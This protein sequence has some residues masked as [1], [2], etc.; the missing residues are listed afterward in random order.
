MLHYDVMDNR[1]YPNVVEICSNIA[2]NCGVNGSELVLRFERASF[3][4]KVPEKAW[5]AQ[6]SPLWMNFV[7]AFRLR[8]RIIVGP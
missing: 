3:T 5:A 1:R 2:V 4:A 7:V 6:R 8:R